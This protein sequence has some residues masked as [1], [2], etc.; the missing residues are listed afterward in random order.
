[1]KKKIFLAML[2][3]IVIISIPVSIALKN[4]RLII[5]L[6]D[7]LILTFTCGFL[8]EERFLKF[9][10]PNL[11]NSGRNFDSILI[12]EESYVKYINRNNMLLLSNYNRNFFVD[13]LILKRYYSFLKNNGE[14]I[15]VF[16]LKNK[17]YFNN[18]KINIIDYDFLHIVTLCENEIN[19]ET[20]KYKVKKLLNKYIFLTYK[21]GIYK[22]F[23]R[24]NVEQSNIATYIEE[25]ERF[26]TERQIKVRIFFKNI[27]NIEELKSKYRNINFEKI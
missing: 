4:L 24:G 20:K 11:M 27:N 1:M 15:F 23:R 7:L 9:R 16:D 14:A 6:L 12:C 10:I 13:F 17:K 8:L 3:I 21:L 22:I 5:M 25:L 2:L 18:K 26:A 19:P